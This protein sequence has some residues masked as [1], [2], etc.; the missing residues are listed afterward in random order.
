MAFWSSPDV[1]ADPYTGGSA[2]N[3]RITVHQDVDVGVRHAQAFVA[4]LDATTV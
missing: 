3:T 4:M 2:G 1:L